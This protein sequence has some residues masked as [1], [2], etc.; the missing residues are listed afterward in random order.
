MSAQLHQLN[1]LEHGTSGNAF[2]GTTAPTFP[3]FSIEIES[4][5]DFEESFGDS[6]DSDS[7]HATSDSEVE[8]IYQQAHVDGDFHRLVDSIRVGAPTSF[9]SKEWDFLTNDQGASG[10][11]G[12]ATSNYKRTRTVRISDE[13]KTLMGAGNQAYVDGDFAKATRMMLQLIRIEPRIASVWAVLAR[14]YEQQNEHQQALKLRI[15]GAHLIRDAD[16]WVC[17]A[18][19]SRNEGCTLQALYCWGKAS[20]L[21]PHDFQIQWSR[22]SLAREVGDLHTARQALLTLLQG[23]PHDL[24]VLS[25]LRTILI[26]I[27]DL[28]TCTTLF[29]GAFEYYQRT[30]PSGQGHDPATGSA[31]PGGGFGTLEMLVLA[32]LYNTTGQHQSAINVIRRGFRW[33]QGRAAHRYWDDCDDDREYDQDGINRDTESGFRTEAFP[34]DV[35]GRHRLAVARIKLGQL[36]EAKFHVNAILSE[37][38]IDYAS[39]FVE[40]ADTYLEQ[41]MF[42]EARPIYELLANDENTSSLYVLLQMAQCLLMLNELQAGAQVYEHVRNLGCADNTTKMKLAGIYELL[43]EPRKALDLVLEVINS[44]A[45]VPQAITVD[46]TQPPAASLFDE[47]QRT[48]RKART[49][50]LSDREDLE[51]QMERENLEQY[52]RIKELCLRSETE[53]E[54]WLLHAGRM[55]ENFRRTPQ[56]FSTAQSYRGMFPG[57]KSRPQTNP[58]DEHRMASR[59]QLQ[60]SRGEAGSSGS[61]RDIFRG[62]HFD[63]W[64]KIFFEYCFTL[65]KQN[66]F[67]SA[68]EIL[69][70]IPHAVPYRSGHFQDS[71]HLAMMTCA[72]RARRPS[73]VAEQF[74][75]LMASRRGNNELLRTL[76]AALGNGL[77]SMDALLDYSFTKVLSR[78]TKLSNHEGASTEMTGGNGSSNCLTGGQ[79]TAHNGVEDIAQTGRAAPG[80]C[81][82]VTTAIY[83]QISVFTP[84]YKSGIFHLLR[85]YDAHPSDPLLCLSLAMSFIGRA[86]QRACDNR[87]YLVTQGMA[88][89]TSYRQ[90]RQGNAN[91]EEEIEYNYGRAFQQI[92]LHSYAVVHYRKALEIAVAKGAHS[93]MTSVSKEAAF[94]LCLIYTMT[95]ATSL[96]D[97][98]YRDWLSL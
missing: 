36:D 13:V 43:N 77:A 20:H 35:N 89:L 78:L 55:I 10:G 67:E 38:L 49:A 63:E 60:L 74:R 22:A 12:T 53:S 56:L 41:E 73:V 82:P 46:V 40:I 44:R 76:L 11:A 90:F 30:Y 93:E 9:L 51:L 32:D 64:L 27:P 45:R 68:R 18:H 79:E 2:P 31:V 19:E 47:G 59:L 28:D 92:G 29:E 84:I 69:E 58:E 87:H 4:R 48:T 1:P 91:T 66:Q 3:F 97:S 52:E 34:L 39:L 8:E 70:H 50:T 72:V 71:I 14:C 86:T 65:T 54:E 61:S 23:H 81:N 7:S 88:F 94:N 57:R 42:E 62:V 75:K 85:V 96:V 98:I 24:T 95:G 80:D 26:E 6:D 37:D 5:G 21:Q 16:E 15:M 83:G 25:E 17:L 33:L